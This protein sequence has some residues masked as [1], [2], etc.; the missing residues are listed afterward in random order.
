M[1]GCR[2]CQVCL[3]PCTQL[4]IRNV[5][6]VTEMKDGSL[7]CRRI[8]EPRVC[9]FCLGDL[10]SPRC[11]L[12]V[13][14]HTFATEGSGVWNPLCGMPFPVGIGYSMELAELPTWARRA[15]A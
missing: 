2:V 4:S 14:R 10:P 9:W 7:E 1:E 3:R 6:E 13:W 5:G 11:C 12:Q 15:L 8:P